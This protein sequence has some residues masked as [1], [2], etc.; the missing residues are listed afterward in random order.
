MPPIDRRSFQFHG[1]DLFELMSEQARASRSARRS[2]RRLMLIWLGN[3]LLIVGGPL[4]ALAA[5]WRLATLAHGVAGVVAAA[6]V[7]VL[8]LSLAGA[9]G[10]WLRGSVVTDWFRKRERLARQKLARRRSSLLAVNEQLRA[11]APKDAAD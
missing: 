11:R 10:W 4:L 5:A 2:R 8:M 9:V 6:A 1:I 3:R 7:A